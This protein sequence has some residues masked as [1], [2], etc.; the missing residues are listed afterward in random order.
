M[1]RVLVIGATG[2]QGHPLLRRLIE[3]GYTPVAALRNPDALK[4]TEFDSVETVQADLMDQSSMINAAKSMSYIASH[5][6]FTF[7]LET[8]QIFG[9][10]IAAAAKANQIKR[11]VFNTSC[12]VHDTDLDIGC[13]LYTSPSPRDL[14]TSRMPSSA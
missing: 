14:S 10:N 11:V 13:L 5:L 12:Y 8:A 4:G 1:E 6:P 9:D 2:D 7:E 3:E